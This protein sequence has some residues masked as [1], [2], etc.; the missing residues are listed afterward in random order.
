MT[1]RRA[2]LAE[3]RAQAQERLTTARTALVEGTGP[4]EDVMTQQATIAALDEDHGDV[5]RSLAADADR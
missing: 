2:R 5:D 4:A 1:E 3:E